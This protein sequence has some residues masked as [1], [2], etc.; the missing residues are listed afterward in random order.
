MARQQAH[1]ER[2]DDIDC[3]GSVGKSGAEQP[4][5]SDIDTMA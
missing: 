2:T 1:D 4:E 5:R 3:E